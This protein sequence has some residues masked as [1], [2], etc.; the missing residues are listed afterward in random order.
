[1]PRIAAKKKEYMVNDF[2]KWIKRKLGETDTRQVEIADKLGISQSAFSTRMKKKEGRGKAFSLIDI[3]T[4]FEELE[5]T[6][7]EILQLMKP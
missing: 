4:L 6:P 1:M 2:F 3:L 7:E 5:A